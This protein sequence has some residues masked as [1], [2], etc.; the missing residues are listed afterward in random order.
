MRLSPA[1][2][3]I[4]MLCSSSVVS[5]QDNE[6]TAEEESEPSES[7]ASESPDN[8]RA[9]GEA[10]AGK[11]SDADSSEA[12]AASSEPPAWWFG[13]YLQ[14]AWVPSFM[15]KLFLDEAP[16]V[17]NVGFGVTATHRDKNGF[18]LVIGLG[19]AS[20]AFDGPFR[21]KGDPEQDT[22]Y[23]SSTLGLLHLRGEMLWSTELV[24]DTLSFEYGFGVDFGLVL[25][26]MKRNEAFRSSPGA[27]FQPCAG[28][29]APAT[30][31]P[32]GLPYCEL[33]VRLPSD[34]YN[35]SGAHYNIVEKRVPPVAL[36][37]MLPV[38]ALRYTPIRQLAVKLEAAFGLLQFAVGV[39]VA[40]GI[41]P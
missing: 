41:N 30:L 31:S 5:A 1:W 39:S 33:P 13:A 16:T 15:L 22:E 25:G 20:Y 40:Y 29:L 34:A 27:D 18:S 9:D 36:V 14:G 2:I 17:G 7:S 38:L 35:A 11:P 6:D 3:V 23:L 8:E 21:I 19:Y 10:G 24:P 32:A 12:T 37:P 26:Q 28:P 4:A